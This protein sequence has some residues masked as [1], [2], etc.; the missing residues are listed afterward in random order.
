MAIPL[1]VL[2]TLHRSIPRSAVD[3][4]GSSAILLIEIDFHFLLL[5]FDQET[6]VERPSIQS[7]EKKVEVTVDGDAAVIRLSS[8]ANGIGWFVQ[9][10][11]SLDA[12]M[13]DALTDEL[14]AARG[15]IVRESDAI[16]SASF[17][18]F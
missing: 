4:D 3:D 7:D 12:D 11:I 6:A 13:L 16:L 1:S 2:K 14:A 15:K 8:Y 10:T 9:K 5:K 17:L 18:E